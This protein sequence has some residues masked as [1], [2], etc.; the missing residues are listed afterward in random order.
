MFPEI[1]G[2]QNGLAGHFDGKHVGI[3]GRVIHIEG[4]NLDTGN[5]CHP[6]SCL[7][8]TH[9]FHHGKTFFPGIAVYIG[10]KNPQNILGQGADVHGDVGG[11]LLEQAIV[12]PMVVGK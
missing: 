7:I 1:S 12:V 3:Q 2:I 6:R 10:D 4:A 9:P 5:R 11:D 8:G